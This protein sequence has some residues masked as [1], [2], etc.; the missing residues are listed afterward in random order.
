[1]SYINHDVRTVTLGANV[2]TGG[3]FTATY[4]A[5]KTGNDYRG[6]DDHQIISASTTALFARDGDFSLTFG[7]SNMTVT[8][9]RGRGFSAGETVYLHVDRAAIEEGEELIMANPDRMAPLTPVRVT[10]GIP[11]TADADGAV[12]SQSATLASGLATGING[13][14]AAGGVATFDVP[15]NVV[16]AW[17]NTAV[18]TVTGTD[19]YGNVMR[20]SSASGTSMTGAKAFK[21]ITSVTTSANITGLTVGSGVRLGLPMYLPNVPNVISQL[22]DGA[23]ATA[24]TVVAGDSAVATATTGDVRGTYAPNSAPNGS[25]RFELDVIVRSPEYRGNAQ[26]AG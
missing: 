15:R 18:L 22:Q 6:G 16:A 10:L 12:A 13:A 19:E 17:T 4:P 23:A 26:F 2:A 9:L 14:L 7:A 11:A 5:G 20:E 24:G 1:M 3:T 8:L 21:T 25:L